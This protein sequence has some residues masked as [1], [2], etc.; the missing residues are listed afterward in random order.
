MPTGIYK[1]RN[2]HKFPFKERP[3]MKGR[4]PWN[5]GKKMSDTYCEKNRL[6]HIGQKAWN[7]GKTGIYSKESLDKMSKSRIGRFG[8]KNSSS[9]KGGITKFRQQIQNNINY[10]N[11]RSNVFIRDNYTCIFCNIKSG[12]GKTVILNADHIKPFSVIIK[13]FNIKTLKKALTCNELWD[14]NNGRTLCLECHKKT[15]TY[16]SKIKNYEK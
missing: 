15:D 8:G 14:I 12:N 9:W 10:I 2:G 11:W 1:H 5:K 7:K 3:S 6:S 4:I 13:K 16:L